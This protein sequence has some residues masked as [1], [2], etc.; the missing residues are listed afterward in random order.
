MRFFRGKKGVVGPLVEKASSGPSESDDDEGDEKCHRDER[1]RGSSDDIAPTSS[2]PFQIRTRKPPSSHAD[3][4]YLSS[5]LEAELAGANIPQPNEYQARN[6][7]N[8]I[9][10]KRS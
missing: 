6:T 10:E 8:Y 4:K 1:P 7:F 5:N 2:G 3:I 9:F